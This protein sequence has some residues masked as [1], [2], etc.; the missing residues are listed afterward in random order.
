[1]SEAIQQDITVEQAG[2][3]V[4]KSP[5]LNRGAR[6]KVTVVIADGSTAQASGLKS[7]IG[8]GSGCFATPEEADD[9]LREERD[10]WS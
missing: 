2:I 1:M 3:I 6:A 8:S 4:I 9:F 5:R 7:L 10:T